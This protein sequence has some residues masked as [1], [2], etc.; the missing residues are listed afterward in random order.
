[1]HVSTDIDVSCRAS[2][3]RCEYVSGPAHIWHIPAHAWGIRRGAVRC[4]YMCLCARVCACVLGSGVAHSGE[5][6]G[7]TRSERLHLAVFCVFCV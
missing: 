5:C 6:V 1:M 7:L 2:Q 4:L 3:R